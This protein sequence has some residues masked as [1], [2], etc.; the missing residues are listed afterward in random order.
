MKLSSENQRMWDLVRQC[1]GTLH[2]NGYIT[3]AEHDLLASDGAAVKRLEDYDAAK[4]SASAEIATAYRAIAERHRVQLPANEDDPKWLIAKGACSCGKLVADGITPWAELWRN[5]IISLTPAAAERSLQVY[6]QERVV[7]EA[8]AA[9]DQGWQSLGSHPNEECAAEARIP[10]TSVSFLCVRLAAA[11][12][13]LAE[14]KGEKHE[15]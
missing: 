3:D 14:L 2:M 6:A 9:H 13:R 4:M 10:T 11:I 1:R 7:E 5:H 15:L 12:A 8:R